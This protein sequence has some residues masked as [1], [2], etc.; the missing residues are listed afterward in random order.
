MVFKANQY[1]NLVRKLLRKACYSNNKKQSSGNRSV[2]SVLFKKEK[3][4][5][6][7]VIFYYI[8]KVLFL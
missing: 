4:M 3:R 6:M 5:S 7:N 2:F 1:A 8:V